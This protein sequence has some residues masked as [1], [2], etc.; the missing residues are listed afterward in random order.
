MYSM[1]VLFQEVTAFNVSL[2][3]VCSYFKSID[4]ENYCHLVLHCI[5]LHYTVKHRLT[6]NSRKRNDDEKR[7]VISLAFHQVSDEGN[8]LDRLAKAHF[9]SQDSIQVVVIERH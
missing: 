3:Q 2:I 9:I 8:G 1:V 4:Y 6:L 5:T 7:S